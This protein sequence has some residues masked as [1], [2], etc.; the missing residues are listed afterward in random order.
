MNKSIALVVAG[1]RG[2]R[3]G[4]GVPKQYRLLGGKAVIRHALEAFLAHPGVA[5][6]QPVIHAD[7]AGLFADVARGLDL[8]EPVAGGAERQDSVRNGLKAVEALGPDAVLIHDAA[9]PF[10]P[11]D[12]ISRV[13]GALEVHAGA[14][15][16]LAV[17]DTLKRGRD[18]CIVGTVDREGL[19][20]AQTPQGFRF[21]DIL[22]AH[23]TLAG[24]SLTDDASLMEE[25]GHTV[26]LVAGSE[27]NFKMTTSEDLK[28]AER[29]TARETRVG[30]G[31]DV[32]GV[33]PGNA[34]ILCGI[35]IPCTFALK[36]HSDADVAMHAITDA[37]LGA[38][39][40][41]DIGSHFPSGDPRWKGAASSIFLEH[42]RDLVAEAGGRIVNVDL[43]VICEAPRIGP[44]REDMRNSLAGILG[45]DPERIGVKGTT[46]E[47]L[48]YTGRGEGI[49]AQ[50]VATVE[51]PQD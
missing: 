28:R 12:V 19:Y 39:G 51:L 46:T 10:V 14:I 5:A 7:D 23:G 25:A 9:R 43:T 47:K 42:T 15:P 6:V 29:L 45:V 26:A 36:G 11:A 41:G 37:V 3:F 30:T 44:H 2:R 49:A 1:G 13:I 17:A 22:E 32:H 50:A 33:E 4:S 18:G 16:A 27:E 8:L 24:R 40:A 48:G 21:A 31:F 35:T 38:I 20:R 34:V